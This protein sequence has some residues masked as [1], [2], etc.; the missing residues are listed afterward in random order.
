MNLESATLVLRTSSLGPNDINV[1]SL[2]N[3]V[4]WNI[5]LQTCLGSMFNK[6]DRFKICLTSVGCGTPPSALADNNRT[7]NINIE[8]LQWNNQSY[9]SQTGI[10]ERNV[11]AST[12]QTGTTL[13][14]SINYTGETGF[15]FYRPQSSDVQ[16]RIYLTRLSD[17]QI[18]N[19]QYGNFV[20]CFSIY[21]I[22]N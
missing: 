7:L 5:N 16:I 11:I 9:N 10:I 12:I 22:E 20:Y 19:I 21:G 8:G 1:G 2:N 18:A 3:D 4:T 13:S 15:V 6:Y 17:N 14:F